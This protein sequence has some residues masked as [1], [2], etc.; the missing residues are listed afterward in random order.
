MEPLAKMNL[1]CMCF[2][3]INMVFDLATC[4]R[5]N[6]VSN[7]VCYNTIVSISVNKI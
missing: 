4:M 7:Y 6:V 2:P 3:E 5:F 1:L